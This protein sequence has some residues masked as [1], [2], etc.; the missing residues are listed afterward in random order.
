MIRDS[1]AS[2]ERR[3]Q[4]AVEEEVDLL[5]HGSEDHE[6]KTEM[7]EKAKAVVTKGSKKAKQVVEEHEAAAR[8][9]LPFE[10]HPFPYSW[11]KEHHGEHKDINV[12]HAIGSAEKA[13]LHAVEDEVGTLFHEIE[14]HHE[15]DAAKKAEAVVKK[16]VK[17]TKQKVEQEHQ[18]RKEYLDSGNAIEE[19]MRWDLE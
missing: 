4:K 8:R 3:L 16:S 18:K 14:H 15:K 12:L 2:M 11:P 5:F 19:Y 6:K 7:K 9:H 1:I 10:D 13:L 17:K